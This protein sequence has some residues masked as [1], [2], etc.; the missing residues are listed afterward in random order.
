MTTPRVALLGTGIMG[1]GVATNIVKAGIPLTVWNR[2][3]AKAE[4]L[5]ADVAASP[6]EAAEGAVV[7]VTM[8]ADAETTEQTVR[9]AS[10]GAGTVWLQQA[11]VGIE[12]SAR[13]AALADELGI[14]YVDA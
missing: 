3:A 14:M 12:G 1:R 6:A 10:P 9:E 2:T 5:G 4:G 13:L 11:T 7:L 8:L